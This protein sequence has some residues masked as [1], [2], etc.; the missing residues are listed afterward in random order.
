MIVIFGE[1]IPQSI[2]V[3]YGLAIGGFCAPLVLLM[4]WIF[5]PI[6]YPIAKLLDW[7]LGSDE[8]HTFR[9]AELKTFLQFHREGSE[10]LRDDEITILNGVLSLNEKKAQEIMTAI[11]VSAE[12]W[13]VSGAV[14]LTLD[15]ASYFSY[16]F[17]SS[18]PR[19]S[20]FFLTY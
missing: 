2:C 4:M 17:F 16:H 3:R 14:A 7:A 1:I 9:K 12:A 13:C 10:P 19:V 18:I 11:D 20:F 8:G 6:A 5:A 15:T